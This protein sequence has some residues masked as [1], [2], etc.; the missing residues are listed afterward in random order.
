MAEPSLPVLGSALLAKSLVRA[1][2]KPF[3]VGTGCPEINSVLGSG[4]EYGRLTSIAGA[5]GMGKTLVWPCVHPSLAYC[6]L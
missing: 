1:Q 6:G 3:S 2:S 5:S 4:F